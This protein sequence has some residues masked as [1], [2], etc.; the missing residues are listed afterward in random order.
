MSI[1][2]FPDAAVDYII[3]NTPGGTVTDQQQTDDRVDLEEVNVVVAVEYHNDPGDFE[4]IDLTP[5]HEPF[6]LFR[7]KQ[8][9]GAIVLDVNASLIEGEDELIETLEV[10]FETMLEERLMR[11]IAAS[12]AVDEEVAAAVDAAVDEYLDEQ[13]REA[14][15]G[16]F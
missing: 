12:Q 8:E 7:M 13:A 11:Q 4:S 5:A 14:N 16:G 1:D 2:M 10:F 15:D 9:G 6:I 3:A